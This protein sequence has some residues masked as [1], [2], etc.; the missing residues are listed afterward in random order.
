LKKQ[1]KDK[2]KI[3]MTQGNVIKI[4]KD[5]TLPMVFGVLGMVIFNLAD[6]YFVSRLGTNQVAA[7]S[8]TF[9]VV[10]IINSLNQGIGIG[11]SA[12]ISN[13]V[14]EKNQDKIKRV[15]TDSLILGIL[16]A[17]VSII[18]GELTI[19]PLFRL[20]GA[21][22]STLPYIKEYMTIWYAGVPF[23]VIPMIGNNVIRALGDTKVPSMVMMISAMFNIVLDPIMIF[24]LG[25]FPALGVKGAALST[26]ISRAL[27]LTVALYVLIKREK[28]ISFKALKIKEM[29][30]SWRQILFIGLPNAIAKMIIPIGNGIITSLIASYGTAAV[31]GY[32]IASRIEFFALV[33]ISALSSIIPVY[34]G[35]NFGA[36]KYSR[37]KEGLKYS[38]IFSMI[39]GLVLYILLVVLSKPIAHLFTNDPVVIDVIVLY[40]RIVP[41]GYAFQGILLI[42]NGALNAMKHP[43]KAALLNVV[44]MLIV[45]VPLAKITSS[46]WGTK[47]IFGSLVVSYALIGIVSHFIAG[48]EISKLNAI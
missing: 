28:V 48:K 6:T 13:F 17:V 31:A 14:G 43:L 38:E 9:P 47:G 29:L 11:T 34:V 10:L 3:D 44:Q 45:Y 32:G 4:L 23:V 25:L 21:D 20:L 36:Q 24:G 39:Y 16:F 30:D 33:V 2:I 41:I 15:A 12:V 40:M 27:T 42:I 8:F 22:E 37:I 7:L 1:K 19:D 35:Q 5:L 46:L 26:V 18:I